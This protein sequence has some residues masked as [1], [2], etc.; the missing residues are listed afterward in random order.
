MLGKLF[1]PWRQSP[2]RSFADVAV[3]LTRW[4]RGWGEIGAACARSADDTLLASCAQRPAS[5]FGAL[6]LGANNALTFS[7]RRISLEA[8][9]ASPR[10]TAVVVSSNWCAKGLQ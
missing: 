3:S 9:G 8:A 6:A 7:L 2:D 5:A 10:P 1:R 4:F